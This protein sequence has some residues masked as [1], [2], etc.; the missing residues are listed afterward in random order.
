MTE[1]DY[2]LLLGSLRH[3]LREDILRSV[4]IS[5]ELEI[6]DLPDVAHVEVLADEKLEEVLAGRD[7]LELLKNTS[8]LL[9]RDVAVLRAIVVLELRLDENALESDLVSNA[10]KKSEDGVLLLV[11]KLR[12]RLRVL[13]NSNRVSSVTENVIDVAAERGVVD[14]ARGQS[15]LVK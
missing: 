7:Q 8:E 14:K 1:I 2:P 6:V 13:D 4:N 9:G 15:V 12:R 3:V 11:S 5:A 10:L